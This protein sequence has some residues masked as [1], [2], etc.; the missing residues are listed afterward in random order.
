MSRFLQLTLV[1]ACSLVILA[2]EKTAPLDLPLPSFVS[3]EGRDVVL[4]QG[5]VK[6]IIA[7]D[8]SGRVA[9]LQVNDQEVI[10]RSS[11]KLR[12]WGNIL[13]SSP[14][15]EWGWPPPQVLDGDPYDLTATK[16]SIL[17]TSKIDPV[18]GYQ[19]SKRYALYNDDAFLITYTIKNFSKK[20]KRVA[21][22]ELTRVPAAGEVVFPL[23][24]TAP[25][26]GI[27]Y[28]L[29]VSV[30]QGLF[31]FHYEANKIVGDHHK[32]TLDGG[33]GWLAYRNNGLL[34]VK[35]FNDISPDQVI[36]GEQ[37]IELFAHMDHIFLELK[38][39]GEAKTL[40]PGESLT[41]SVIWRAYELPTTLQSAIAP[42]ELADFVRQKI[43]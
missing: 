11:D 7:P 1:L 20:T 32:I 39:Q 10:A 33:D 27:F 31:W 6:M 40:K 4:V 9:S 5:D 29:K 21:P 15:S 8:V 22:L 12:R 23:G 2:C 18:T 13:W 26:S 16:D 34:L 19:F 17:L 3:L 35:Q 24:E 28:P 41:W 14:Q 25:L 37:E 42:E 43:N 30:E 38:H 36:E